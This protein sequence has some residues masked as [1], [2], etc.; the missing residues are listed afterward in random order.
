MLAN[1]S[2]GIHPR[3][4]QVTKGPQRSPCALDPSKKSGVNIALVVREN[5]L[6]K[7]LIHLLRGLSL[8]WN[9]L[10]Q[11]SLNLFRYGSPDFFLSNSFP[12]INQVIYHLM[13]EDS[14]G[15]PILRV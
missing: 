6:L 5:V 8:F 12:V 10:V 13:A 1:G 14:H 4:K 15:I 7:L 9:G 3:G 2:I 11:E